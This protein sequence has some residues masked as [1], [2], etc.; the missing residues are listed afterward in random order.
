MRFPLP[1]DV[2][3]SVELDDGSMKDIYIVQGTDVIQVPPKHIG[4]VCRALYQAESTWR[5]NQ[6]VR[7]P[8]TPYLSE[9]STKGEW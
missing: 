8:K 1:P 5:A 3:L 2:E 9:P 7:T 6:P 4:A